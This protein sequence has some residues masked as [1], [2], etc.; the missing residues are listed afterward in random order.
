[1]LHHFE[2]E[3]T[4]ADT[5]LLRR[6]DGWCLCDGDAQIAISL[7]PDYGAGAT[8]SLDGTVSTVHLVRD[9]DRIFA[10]I[11]GET[12]EISYHDPIALHGAHAAGAAGDHAKAPMPGSV[13]SLGFGPGDAVKRGDV[14]VVIESMK[15]EMAIKAERDG[16][17]AAIHTEP[18]RTFERDQILV[19][20]APLPEE[21]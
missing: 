8:L 2:I 12:L 18:G 7:G 1:M 9:G 6:E 14:L 10:H 16:T 4:K 21:A 15:L 20:L 13:L 17:I 3:G 11:D 5:W 19:S